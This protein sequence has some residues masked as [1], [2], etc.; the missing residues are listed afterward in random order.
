MQVARH[1]VKEVVGITGV[2]MEVD[3]TNFDIYKGR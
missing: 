3:S 1:R 2:T